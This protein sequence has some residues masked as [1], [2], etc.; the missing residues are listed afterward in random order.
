M[1]TKALCEDLE[2]ILELQR[3]AYQSE[4]IIC[5]DF[6]IP[7]LTQTLEGMKQDFKNQIILKKVLDGE[8]IGSVR[9][10]ESDDVCYIG[11]VIVHPERQNG[12]IGTELMSSIERQF[13]QCGK[14]SLF[15]GA[16]SVRNL[17]FYG[18]LGYSPV[19]EERVN[20]KLT[21]VYLE[22]DNAGINN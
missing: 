9:A 19:R 10:Y 1:V 20:E 5:G 18:K 2:E 14:Y 6:N 13:K 17:H 3:Q 8:I 7:P 4:A 22:K 16:K 21:F 12:G 15:T 11:R